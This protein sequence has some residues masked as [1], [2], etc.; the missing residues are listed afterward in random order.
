M[1]LAGLTLSSRS[2]CRVLRPT[3][4]FGV[5]ATLMAA[6]TL[7]PATAVLLRHRLFWPAGLR[8]GL[9]AA[10]RPSRAER[11]VVGRPVGALIASAAVLVA[12]SLPALGF[13]ADYDQTGTV[14]GSPSD[15]AF[16]DLEPGFPE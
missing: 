13:K 5:P 4:G 11:L 8:R 7:V 1:S 2:S 10:K 3:L 16:T 9:H 15:K 12:L 14:P 6:L